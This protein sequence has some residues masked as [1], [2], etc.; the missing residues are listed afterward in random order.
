VCVRSA[1]AAFVHAS[2]RVPIISRAR[3]GL[4][5]MQRGQAHSCPRPIRRVVNEKRNLLGRLGATVASDTL[6]PSETPRLSKDSLAELS[7]DEFVTVPGFASPSLVT[8]L[9][10]DLDGYRKSKPTKSASWEQGAVDWFNLLPRSQFSEFTPSEE[11][12]QLVESVR[13]SIEQKMGVQ[14]AP[15]LTE[16]KFAYYPSGGRYQRHLD[17]MNVGLQAREYSFVLYLNQ[18]WTPKDGGCLRIFREVSP[19]D[20]VFLDVAPAPG[21]MVVFKSDTVP[22]EVLSTNS[23]RVAIVGWFNRALSDEE[24]EA[25]LSE[26]N[27]LSPLA[28]AIQ[29]HY[30]EKGMSVKMG[31]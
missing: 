15:E 29:K 8:A 1:K 31:S 20:E 5:R 27:E 24:K 25:R 2:S 16:V 4:T 7:S 17:A 9:L 26:T 30:R 3:L 19:G 10:E 6:L 14:L 22:H 18:N 11:L 12:L 13:R 23:K 28:A 21:T